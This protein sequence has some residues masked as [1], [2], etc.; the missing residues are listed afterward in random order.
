[1]WSDVDVAEAKTSDAASTA[2]NT[3]LVKE[4]GP[5]PVIPANPTQKHVVLAIFKARARTFLNTKAVVAAWEAH[6]LEKFPQGLTPTNTCAAI[7]SRLNKDD[8]INPHDDTK[9]LYKYNKDAPAE[10]PAGKAKGVPKAP[11]APGKKA[12][13][14]KK[15]RANEFGSPAHKKTRDRKIRKGALGSGSGDNV[16]TDNGI[17]VN[18]SLF[19]MSVTELRDLVTQMSIHPRNLNKM[20]KSE[21]CLV[22]CGKSFEKSTDW[23]KKSSKKNEGINKTKS[24][25]G[26]KFS[27]KM[28]ARDRS[29][30]TANSK[31]NNKKNQKGNSAFL[32]LSTKANDQAAQTPDCLMAD[33]KSR[34]D[35][36]FDPCP[37]GGVMN[38]KVWNGLEGDWKS[39]NYVN[40]PYNRIKFWLAKCVAEQEK[41]NTSVF[42]IPFRVYT[43][44]FGDFVANISFV[45]CL[46]KGVCFK[47]YK[48]AIP[49]PMSLI[50][51][52]GK[53]KT[54]TKKMHGEHTRTRSVYRMALDKPHTFDNACS[55]VRR[56]GLDQ[57]DIHILVNHSKMGDLI[58]EERLAA[59]AKSWDDA[60]ACLVPFYSYSRNFT[61][62]MKE[63][64][65]CAF[66]SPI[67]SNFEG[68][69]K[70]R[71]CSV[72]FLFS[73]Q[74]E[75]FAKIPVDQEAN[76]QEIRVYF[77]DQK[78]K[79]Q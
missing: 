16:V 17:H 47:G 59:A 30:R 22:L 76:L 39:R 5:K 51:F 64:S 73:P 52:L 66:S 71:F 46:V 21:L 44:Y 9:G 45:E 74:D 1:M 25:K 14:N 7:I 58:S 61:T 40:P 79:D 75:R 31:L 4:H 42:L 13:K 24:S 67:L 54:E 56:N 62:A 11:P 48:S 33:L 27:S 35:I 15:K 49:H 29:V 77:N 2:K 37:P 55:I 19:S 32:Q 57:K 10:L 43:R 41:G 60:F 28:N 50:T 23:H 36:N 78:Q 72:L 53:G 6:G 63:S 26:V 8:F 3:E 69:G 68:E 18:T 12:K 65:F 70:V 34:Y 38:Q 20:N